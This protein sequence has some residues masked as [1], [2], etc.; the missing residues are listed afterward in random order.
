MLRTNLIFFAS[1]T[2]SSH[3][4]YLKASLSSQVDVLELRLR[5]TSFGRVG[6]PSKSVPFRSPSAAR[7]QVLLAVR[8]TS[9]ALADQTPLCS[10]QG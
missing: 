7:Y 8:S 1:Y 6:K 4:S 2:D 5:L 9:G 10:S 3:I